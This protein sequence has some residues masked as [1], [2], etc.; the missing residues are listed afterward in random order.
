MTHL[1]PIL[2]PI[3]EHLSLRL[4]K[5]WQP[6]LEEKSIK[7]SL[8]SEISAALTTRRCEEAATL[9]FTGG[10]AWFEVYY[11]RGGLFVGDLEGTTAEAAVEKVRVD[12]SRTFGDVL[13]AALALKGE[14]YER[15]ERLC[16][17]LGGRM[18]TSSTYQS[19]SCCLIT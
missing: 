14:W 1:S 2:E 12:L 7:R 19:T 11:A 5:T 6:I 15:Q 10:D 18:S 16:R 13:Q 9:A 3:F 17:C 4:R 8:C